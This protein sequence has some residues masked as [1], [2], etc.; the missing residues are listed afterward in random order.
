MLVDNEKDMY[1]H[2]VL[3]FVVYRLNEPPTS[4]NYECNY[5]TPNPG[6]EKVLLLWDQGQAVGFATIRLVYKTCFSEVE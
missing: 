4:S 2:L 5:G 1:R 3:N 6:L